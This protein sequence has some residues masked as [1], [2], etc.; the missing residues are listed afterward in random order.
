MQPTDRPAHD[1][2][3]DSS[4]EPQNNIRRNHHQESPRKLFGLIRTGEHPTILQRCGVMPVVRI[5]NHEAAYQKNL[6]P[7]E[8]RRRIKRLSKPLKR[9]RQLEWMR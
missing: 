2:R 5:R 1:E 6:C 4:R 3:D 9:S 8:L 7:D